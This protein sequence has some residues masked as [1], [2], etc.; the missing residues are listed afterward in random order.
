MT[1]TST[2]TNTGMTTMNEELK[3][4]PFCGSEQ[5]GHTSSGGASQFVCSDCDQWIVGS[6]ED[7]STWEDMAI[8][9]NTRT[10]PKVKPLVWEVWGHEGIS[11]I[12]KGSRGGH[13]YKLKL[14]PDES[15]NLHYLGFEYKQLVPYA[16]T[17]AGLEWF[18]AAAQ[19][20]Y[21]R[22]VRE[23]LL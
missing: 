14:H 18:K 1:N 7:R 13:V 6:L 12:F 19:A 15:G 2:T 8:A 22:R 20:D 10:A 4:C 23:C 9:W 21:E 5:I 3:P 11:K 16:T 17:K